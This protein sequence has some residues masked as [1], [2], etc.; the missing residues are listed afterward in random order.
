MEAL[1]ALR[2]CFPERGGMPVSYVAISGRRGLRWIL[3]ARSQRITG[4]MAGW[5]PYSFS[6]QL[7]WGL[8]RLAAKGGLLPNLPGSQQFKVDIPNETWR[9]FGWEDKNPPTILAYVGTPGPH[10]KI[11][12]MLADPL[13]GMGRLVVKCPFVQTAWLKIASE[14]NVLSTLNG[15]NQVLAP[16]PV[17]ID[18]VKQ[19]SVQT[20]LGGSPVSLKLT[21][22][23]YHFLARLG[24][25][26]VSIALEKIRDQITSRRVALKESGCLSPEDDATLEKLLK[27]TL[28]DGQVPSVIQHG[29]FTPWNLKRHIGGY[30][31]GIDWEDARRIG[32]PFYDLHYYKMQVELL[33]GK[34]QKISE[35]RYLCSLL[36]AGYSARH[37]TL[38]ATDRAAQCLALMDTKYKIDSGTILCS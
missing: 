30:I 14:Y 8:L 37:R 3:P 36:E 9:D 2:Q 21:D 15:G 23:H 35:D 25:P 20:H 38:A 17:H 7:G 13:S 10:Q 11:V 22:D 5:R 28:W 33:T 4:L 27:N 31:F 32:L 12:I 29:D 34:R 19:F 1:E 16:S 26:E 18:H 6:A 24:Q